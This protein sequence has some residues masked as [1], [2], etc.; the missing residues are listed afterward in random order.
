M[1]PTVSALATPKSV[2]LVMV[3]TWEVAS[4]VKVPV[5]NWPLSVFIAALPEIVWL[6]LPVE[7][8]KN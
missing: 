5:T 8:A 4:A 3:S 1:V 7:S 2:V 6:L